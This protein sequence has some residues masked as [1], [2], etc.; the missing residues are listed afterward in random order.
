MKN[1]HNQSDNFLNPVEKAICKYKFLIKSK[2]KNQRLFSF[3]PKF[4]MK[5]VQNIDPKMAGTKNT[6][7]PDSLKLNCNTS[8]EALQN[9]NNRQFSR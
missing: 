6:I 9:L 7:P 4:E 8:V 5:K 3:K 2:L 1:V